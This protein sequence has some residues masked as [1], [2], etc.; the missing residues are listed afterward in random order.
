MRADVR[1]FYRDDIVLLASWRDLFIQRWMGEGTPDHVAR[2]FDSHRRFVQG[3]PARATVAL[4]HVSTPAIKPPDERSRKLMR[5]YVAGMK[6]IRAVATVI[7]ASGFGA[8]MVRGIVSGLVLLTQRDIVHAVHSTLRDG[9]TFLVRYRAPGA[10]PVTVD[11]LEG[12]YASICGAA[13]T[14]GT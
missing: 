11:E 3:H 8:A 13:P 4:S 12:I 6:D 5:D 10:S 7:D 14:R 2:M 1:V 9:L